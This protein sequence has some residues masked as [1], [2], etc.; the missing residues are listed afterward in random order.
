M[1]VEEPGGPDA[2]SFNLDHPVYQVT[3]FE[4]LAE[5]AEVPEDER[6]YHL[7]EW[8]IHETEVAEVLVWAAEKAVGQEY[9][10]EVASVE[11]DG[12][13]HLLRLHGENPN[14]GGPPSEPYVLVSDVVPDMRDF[15]RR[16]QGSQ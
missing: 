2:R 6:G 9:T 7:H 3:I 4:R 13:S 15:I 11:V 10:D 14:R 12:E 16:A 1:R 8:K 5:P